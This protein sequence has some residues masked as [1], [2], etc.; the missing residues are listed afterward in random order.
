MNRGLLPED[1]AELD[2]T[3]WPAADPQG[4]TRLLTRPATSPGPQRQTAPDMFTFCTHRCLSRSSGRAGWLH[5]AELLGD[6]AVELA[7]PARLGAP[8][9][10]QGPGESLVDEAA[11]QPPRGPRRNAE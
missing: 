1:D 5:F 10:R 3:T 11:E 2:K 8:A 7:G 6:Q 9:G 4:A